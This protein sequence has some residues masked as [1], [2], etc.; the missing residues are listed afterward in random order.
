MDDHK[1]GLTHPTVWVG[2]IALTLLSLY[3]VKMI[4]WLALP[5][6]MA[7]IF[8]YI[9][10][11][12]IHMLMR[13]GLSHSQAIWSYIGGLSL[14]ILVALPWFLPWLGKEAYDLQEKMP[15]FLD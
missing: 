8:Y 3:V 6:L 1:T 2:V 7:G 13:R 14:I 4:W 5:F 10:I 15:D 12:M 9:S 11:P